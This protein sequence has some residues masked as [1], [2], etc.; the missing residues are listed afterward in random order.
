MP[1][2]N[3]VVAAKRADFNAIGKAFGID[4]VIARLIR[5]RDVTGDDAI[6]LYLDGTLRDLSDPALM[7]GMPEAVSILKNALSE[8][9]KIRIIGD[10]DIDGI[11]SSFI[12][13]KALRELGAD[14]DVR[15]PER[16]RDGYGLNEH[17]VR[18]AAE[19]GAELI[20]TCD[21]GISASEQIRLAG[22]LGL[23]TIVTDHHE[24]PYEEDPETGMRHY[25]L[26]PADAVID[27]KQDECRYPFKGLCG[28]GVA[29]RLIQALY[30]AEGLPAEKAEAFL[31]YVAI[32]TV[33]DV[34][35]LNGENRILV[36]EGLKKL[37]CT[38]GTGLLEL[39]RRNGI[40]PEQ[41]DVYHI[42]F[43]IGPCLNASG[44]L[45]TAK[46]AL[47]LLLAEDRAE[48]ARL[49]GDLISLNESRKYMTD[50]GE[51]EAAAI[52]EST[53][54]ANDRV[55]VVFLPDCH[56]SIAGII[57]GRLKERYCRPA[58]VLTR[59]EKGVKGSGRSV[60]A[61][62]MYEELTR[63]RDLLGQ[64]GGHPMA[65][66]LS[67]PEENVDAFRRKINE[68]C[69]LT[70]RDLTPKITIDIAMPFSYVS[71]EL[72]RQIGLLR[73]FG[74]GNTRPL[75]AEKDLAVSFLRV[76][77]KNRNVA[78]MKLT[79]PQG[80]SIQAVYFGEADAF[81]QYVQ[82]HDRIA[83][84]YYPG[85]DTWQGRR[86]LQLTIVSYR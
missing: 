85:L 83:V 9:W 10:Y 17:L 48:A 72:I 29:F 46:R 1:N 47:Q 15:I 65:A 44:R 54:L 22:E 32:A 74:K 33:G 18:Q 6:R 41:V 38:S 16:I 49:A 2:E 80:R 35:D 40:E 59:T 58:F 50:Q 5:N 14:A 75:F 13:L 79:D 12:L 55:L 73:P 71:E 66:G 36:K 11:M 3:W 26:P 56:E 52:V 20:L 7:K 70:E 61:Y 24:V 19:D 37:H 4:P 23:R 27:P 28:A 51:K 62:S 30:R 76:F 81:A 68:L 25:L 42:G 53:S 64:F 39:I 21:N 78:K 69:T 60:E 34:M 8:H 77:G 45:D 86:A 63:C 82:T 84:I 31:E 57:A 67:L 43:V